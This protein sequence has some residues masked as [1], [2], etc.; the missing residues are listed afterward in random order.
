M[1]IFIAY[2]LQLQFRSAG[3]KNCPGVNI[4]RKMSRESQREMTGVEMSSTTLNN[5]IFI[6]SD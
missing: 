4:L 1:T 2:P 5:F 6:F 3:M